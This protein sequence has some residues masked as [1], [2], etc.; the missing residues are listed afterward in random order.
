M[1]RK[2]ELVKEVVELIKQGGIVAFTGA[3]IS[4]ESGIPPF[5][6]AKGL[7]TK[8][9]PEEYAYIE[10]FIKNPEKVWMMLREMY[11]CFKEAKPNPAHLVLAEL[12]NRGYLEAVIT[13]NIDNLHQKAG[14]KKVI[15]LHGSGESLVCLNCGKKYRFTEEFL[16]MFPCPKCEKC[17]KA[18]KPEIVFFGEPLPEEALNQA[19]ELIKRCKALIIIG[20]SG[21]V[22]P[23]AYLPYE[24]KRSGA[25]IIE[26]NPEESA[27]TESITDY[28]FKERAGEFFEEFKRF[29][30]G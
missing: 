16:K 10:T 22:Y 1:N 6:G 12:E 13:Q 18:L 5:R 21:V 4:V 14:S 17:G 8:Y 25:K 7:W 28:F 20:T 30:E 2:E 19:F 23:A 29:L 11:Q 15:E 24:A 9:N 27:Y 26:V 3:G